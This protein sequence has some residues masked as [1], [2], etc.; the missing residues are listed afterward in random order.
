MKIVAISVGKRHDPHLNEAIATYEKRL[1]RYVAFEWH[2]I[3]SSN[4]DSESSAILRFIQPEDAVVLLD[5]RG[6]QFTNNQ[7]AQYIERSNNLSVKKIII[8]IGGAYGVN[9]AVIAR[10]AVSLSLSNLVFPHQI[11]R[12][13]LVEQLYRTYSMLDGSSYHHD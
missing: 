12:L 5:E 13:L 7:L 11:V 9:S 4:V 8:V 2:I 1:K 6:Q 10:A 3:A